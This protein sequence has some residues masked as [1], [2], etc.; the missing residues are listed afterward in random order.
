MERDRSLHVVRRGLVGGASLVL[1]LGLWAASHWNWFVETIYARHI[2]AWIARILSLVTGLV[3]GSLA[4]F[5]VAAV[6]LYALVPLIFALVNVVRR[7]RSVRNALIGESLRLVTFALFA[8]AIFYVVWGL[9]YARAPLAT[10]LGWAPLAKPADRAESDT[11][12]E[13]VAAIASE[14]VEAANASYRDYAG[15]NDIGRPST[16]PISVDAL[17]ATIE[18]A[19]PR[20]QAQL[21]AEPVL[22]SR[23]GHAK[24]LLA[25][26]ALNYLGLTGFYFPWSGEANFNTLAPPPTM[27]HTIAHEKAHQRGIARED[28]A[29]FVGFL[30]CLMSDDPYVRYSGYLF[31][32]RQLLSELNNRNTR[33][34]RELAGQRSEGVWRD[35]EFIVA[36]SIKYD[37]RATRM[38]ESV[39]NSFIRA[40]GDRRGTAAYAASRSLIL[41]YARSRGGKLR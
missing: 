16:L 8:L 2:G 30:A 15:S 18:A 12:T 32:S 22:G 28:E 36:Y 21:Q 10:R 13:E 41:L 11:Q 38:R 23:R 9:N 39:N 20:V 35:I 33:R 6:V 29:N 24:A 37:G 7:R 34:A 19:Y 17:D 25:S 5:T 3:P 4:E 1:L 27:P 14:L 31:G 40:Q 26:N